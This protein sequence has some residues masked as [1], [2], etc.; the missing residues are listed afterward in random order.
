MP[1][2]TNEAVKKSAYFSN[3]NVNTDS[4]TSYKL[5]RYLAPFFTDEDKNLA[6]LDIGCGLGQTLSYLKERGFTDLYGID[7]NNEAIESC[8]SKGIP[9]EKINDTKEFALNG[10]RKYDRIIMSHVLE[11]IP[12]EDI[13]DTLSHIKKYLLK[14]NGLFLLM[15]PNAQSPTGSYWRY[16]DFTHNTLFTAGS[17]I[18]VLRA[19]GFTTIEFVDPDGTA[20]MH[21]VKKL[22]IK[23]I[24]AWYRLKEKFWHKVLQ[25]SY[26]KGSPCIYTFEL[27]VAA[28]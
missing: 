10:G 2:T 13:V 17:C 19:A 15:V 18:Y 25:T 1:E 5:P 14:D 12:K 28:R 20:H 27:K 4:Y 24:I 6:V 26:H 23:P 11:H 22:I 7:I 3:R 9:V 8:L 21:P 16:E